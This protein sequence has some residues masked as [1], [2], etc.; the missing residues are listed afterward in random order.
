MENLSSLNT[1]IKSGAMN[2]KISNSC[3]VVGLEL[4]YFDT[5]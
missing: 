5:W 3:Q 1:K 4:M 2:I